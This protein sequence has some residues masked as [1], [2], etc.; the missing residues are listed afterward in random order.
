[1]TRIAVTGASCY[2]G[3]SVAHD[4][5]A[6]G[7]HIVQLGRSR[8]SD[9]HFALNETPSPDLFDGI[10]K[11]VHCAWNVHARKPEEHRANVQGSIAL[12]ELA[13][14]SGVK[15]AI[16]I[17]SMAAFA[18]CRSD[19]GRTKLEVETAVIALG[20]T[21]IRPGLLYSRDPRGLFGTLAS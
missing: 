5:Q 10:D 6:R 12:F 21:V 3:G 14:A 16:F 19:H 7:S 2:V 11:L 17:S 9:R 20:A 13:R 18:G 1:M 15:T 4:L 8:A